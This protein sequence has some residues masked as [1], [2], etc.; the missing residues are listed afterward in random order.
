MFVIAPALRRLPAV[1]ALTGYIE[2]S[3]IEAGALYYTGL[4]ETAEA[5]MYFHNAKEYAPEGP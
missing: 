4:D 2:E 5:E 1:G 3:G